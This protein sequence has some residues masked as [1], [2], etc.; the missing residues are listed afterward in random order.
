MGQRAGCAWALAIVATLGAEPARAQALA[1]AH[2][3]PLPRVPEL[4]LKWPLSPLATRYVES[5]VVG[6]ANGP[7][8]L[9]RAESLWFRASRFQLL[10]F[11]SSERAFELDCRLTCQPIEARTL[12]LEGRLLLP[13][14]T[15]AVSD[16]HLFA[17]QSTLRTPLAPRASGLF[18]IG[19]GGS[20]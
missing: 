7:L 17:R 8:Q 1:P 14:V 5:E 4:R 11:S 2:L 3:A 12:G 15:P 18:K 16:L 20:F 19:L 10:S 13:S 9:F 6:Y